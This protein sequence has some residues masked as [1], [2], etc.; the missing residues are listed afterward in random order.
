MVRGRLP[1]LFIEALALSLLNE[2][3]VRVRVR[4]SVRVRVRHR[5]S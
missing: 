4:V 3:R 1:P 2:V 5:I